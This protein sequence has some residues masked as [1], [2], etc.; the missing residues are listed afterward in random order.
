[1]EVI[2]LLAGRVTL[3]LQHP[4]HGDPY[5]LY[6]YLVAHPDGPVLVDTGCGPGHPWIDEHF[7]PEDIPIERALTKVGIEVSDVAMIIN[8]HL[9]FDHCGQNRRFPGIPVVVQRAEFEA[10]AESGY[11][12]PD[13]LGFEAY[14]WRLVDGETEVID[15]VSVLPTTS[16][17]PGH[18]AVVVAASAGL[19]VIAGQ[20]VQ[21]ADE[22]A[23]EASKEDLP[24]AGTEGFDVVARRIK[25]L[26]P[27][28][29]WF[30]HD[31]R[32]WAPQ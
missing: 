6:A 5:P 2:Q 12:V 21:D 9:H 7:A 27:V 1:M 4:R 25:A 20:A 18:Q 10:A 14:N 19:E 22:L 31:Q 11:T 30:S 17:T 16:H 15:G 3:P 8:T 23:I 26:A 32:V 29:V 24:R 13:W 28:R